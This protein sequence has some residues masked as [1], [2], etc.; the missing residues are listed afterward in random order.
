MSG[1]VYPPYGSAEIR[2]RGPRAGWALGL[3]A[4]ALLAGCSFDWGS[5]SRGRGADAAVPSLDGPGSDAGPADGHHGDAEPADGHHDDAAPAGDGPG[6]L[7]ACGPDVTLATPVWGRTYLG[8]GGG[9]AVAG[10]SATLTLPSSGAGEGWLVSTCEWRRDRDFSVTLQITAA[11]MGDTTTSFTVEDGSTE[12]GLYVEAADNRPICW[13][14]TAPETPVGDPRV[15]PWTWRL[16]R[17][18]SSYGCDVDG[19][20][21]DLLPAG[22]EL[23]LDAFQVVI[24]AEAWETTSSL[25]RGSVTFTGL[26]VSPP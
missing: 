16:W 17:S 9:W 25:P 2:G 4:V 21:V 19:D 18:G 26:S 3:T 24:G 11:A 20:V 23:V 1:R 12:L 13:S 22:G 5:L 15:L 10:E 7:S 6:G 14:T 8:S